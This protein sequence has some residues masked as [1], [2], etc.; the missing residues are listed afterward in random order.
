MEKPWKELAR[1]C[2]VNGKEFIVENGKE[3]QKGMDEGTYER[4]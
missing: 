1:L 3:M 2:E 4:N